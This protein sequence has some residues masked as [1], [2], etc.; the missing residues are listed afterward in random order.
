MEESLEGTVASAEGKGSGGVLLRMQGIK[1]SYG[2]VAALTNADFDLG[3]REVMA[4]LGENG[5]GKST[6]VKILAGLVV[7]DEG[8]IEIDGEEATLHGARESRVHGIAVVQQEL[9]LVPTLSAAENVFLGGATHN[10]VW[11]RRRLVRAARPF[12]EEVGLGS[13]DSSSLA[14]SLTVA[15]RQL[16]EVARLLASDARILIFD[17]PTAS[18]AD[19][20]IAR[21]QTVVRSLVDRGR[22]VIYVTHRLDEVFEIADRVTVLRNG[23]SQPPRVTSKLTMRS[24]VEQ[25]LGRPLEQMYPPRSA[26]FGSVRVQFNGVL[27]EGIVEPLSLTAHAGEI[28]GLAGQIGSGAERVLRTAAGAQPIEAGE[29]DIA[30]RSYTSLSP[31]R[32]IAAGIAYCSP[33]RKFDGLFAVR[34][35]RENLTAPALDRVSPGGWIRTR[36]ERRLASDLASRFTIDVGRLGSHASALSGGNQQKV[37]LG[38][39]LGVEPGILLVEEPTRGV[40]VGAR[41]EIYSH[42]RDLANKGMAVMIASTDMP[43]VLGL[44]DTIASFYRGRLVRVRPATETTAHDL[45]SDVTHVAGAVRAGA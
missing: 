3:R 17:E 32:A 20:E 8:T 18:L 30:G 37:A 31:R 13:L 12:L 25:M 15:E 35:V 14:A 27:T 38:K 36:R 2:A 43:E 9:S 7:P 40:D 44:A 5:A 24:L 34:T 28:V 1:K 19:V 26:G 42:I 6:L 45:L 21:V 29:I 23:V 11:S 22:S 39:W 41:A 33:E 10:G 4:L 16:V